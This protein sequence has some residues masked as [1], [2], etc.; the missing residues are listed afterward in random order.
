MDFLPGGQPS[1]RIV[2]RYRRC[3]ASFGRKTDARRHERQVHQS[4]K[5][6]CKFAGCRFRG[7]VRAEVMRRHLKSKHLFES[8]SSGQDRAILK[9]CPADPTQVES[10]FQL[11][12]DNLEG[13]LPKVKIP[14]E[15][16]FPKNKI[17]SFSNWSS[18]LLPTVPT[19]HETHK[20]EQLL[21]TYTDT[22][23]E[24]LSGNSIPLSGLEEIDVEPINF[25]YGIDNQ[26]TVDQYHIGEIQATEIITSS[27]HCAPCQNKYP[28]SDEQHLGWQN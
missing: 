16:S 23:N 3:K 5:I 2:C 17:G 8:K 19:P 10:T 13:G 1:P 18:R 11:D 20:V 27:S 28:G 9:T 22:G 6:F 24:L 4:A 15:F 21:E 26:Q 25:E 7:T 14:R 12:N